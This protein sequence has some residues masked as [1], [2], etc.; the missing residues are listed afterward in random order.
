M[1]LVADKVYVGK[2][3]RWKEDLEG[4]CVVDDDEVRIDPPMFVAKSSVVIGVVSE[5]G[6][7]WG[8]IIHT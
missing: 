4:N 5:R 8:T 7:W 6:E 2:I 3:P 1:V